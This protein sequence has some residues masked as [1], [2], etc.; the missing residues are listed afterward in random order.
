MVFDVE[1]IADVL[2]GYPRSARLRKALRKLEEEG[3]AGL[4]E[5]QRVVY[6]DMLVVVGVQLGAGMYSVVDG[7]LD[8]HDPL[9]PFAEAWRGVYIDGLLRWF[10]N[11]FFYRIPVFVEEPDPKRFVLAP[12][13]KTLRSILPDWARIRV[14]VPGPYTFTKLSKNRTGR[15]D[16]ELME[17]IARLL[18]EEVR[19]A[20][21]AGASVVQVDEPMFADV[22]AKP[23]EASEAV[24]AVNIVFKAAGNAETRLAIPYNVPSPDIYERIL[25]V[26]AKTIILDF[27]DAFERGLKLVR[28]KGVGGHELGAGVIEA[29]NIYIEP[30]ER[31]ASQLNAIKSVYRGDR[32]LVTT[33]AWL[34]LIPFHYAVE[35]TRILGHY[36]TRYASAGAR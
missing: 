36:T 34:D 6:E 16:R 5:V 14:V 18:A 4:A 27:V 20:V 7:M 23:D 21:E 33:S 9:R 35:K 30:Y 17:I 28:E 22:D 15:N 11:N 26:K 19:R 2:G 32:L 8:W 1:F 3:E 10:D 24:E 13:V 25:D 31:F 29:R 12:R